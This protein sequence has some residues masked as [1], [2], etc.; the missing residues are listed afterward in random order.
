MALIRFEPLEGIAH[1]VVLRG[2][3]RRVGEVLEPAPSAGAK[4]LA[5]WLDAVGARLENSE[6]LRLGEAALHLRDPCAYDVARQRTPHEHHEAV[7]PR[8]TVATERE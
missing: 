5:A 4:V 6:C 1:L 8:D 7:E 2:R 3:L